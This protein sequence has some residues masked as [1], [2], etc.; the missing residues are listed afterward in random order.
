MKRLGFIVL[1]CILSSFGICRDLSKDA[2]SIDLLETC[3]SLNTSDSA[4]QKT[5]ND[6]RF[7]GWEKKDWLDN[8][9]I[10]ELRKY[11]DAYNNGEVK[12]S[13]LD[14]YKEDV[15][16]KFIIGGTEPFLVGGLIIQIIFFDKPGKIFDAWVYSD[17]DKE[18]EIVTGYEVREMRL[19]TENSGITKDVILQITDEH[20]ELKF[21]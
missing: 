19:E 17:V 8:E 13:D 2:I 20:P 7:E 15:K 9:Y 4:P 6:I 21:W 10:K 18:K 3:D 12:N 16:G 11:L 5:L 14:P 1:L